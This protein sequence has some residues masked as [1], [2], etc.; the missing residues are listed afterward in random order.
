MSFPLR[1][2]LRFKVP[3]GTEVW[4]IIVIPG[5]IGGLAGQT[6]T[7]M[8][9]GIPVDACYLF[10]LPIPVKIDYPAQCILLHIVNMIVAIAIFSVKPATKQM[11]LPVHGERSA[12]MADCIFRIADWWPIT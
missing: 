5:D 4:A 1:P 6:A 10:R 9:T 12:C 11:I 7:G 2:L 8:I 3:N